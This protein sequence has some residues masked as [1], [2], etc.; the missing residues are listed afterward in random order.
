MAGWKPSICTFLAILLMEVIVSV[1]LSAVIAMGFYQYWWPL[2]V[3]TSFSY[4]TV[5][6]GFSVVAIGGYLGVAIIPRV[7]SKRGQWANLVARSRVLI[8]NRST[9][10]AVFLHLLSFVAFAASYWVCTYAVLDVG[11]IEFQPYFGV[12][13][14]ATLVGFLAFFAPAGF[15]VRE[16]ILFSFLLTVCEANIALILSTIP[17]LLSLFLDFFAA[18]L[19]FLCRRC[20][21]A[22]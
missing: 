12:L 8:L 22:E 7:I 18:A 16:G 21:R 9:A 13:M 17:R 1:V 10:I 2:L 6:I 14:A 19:F 20:L 5:V 15:G 11:V 4:W 3:S